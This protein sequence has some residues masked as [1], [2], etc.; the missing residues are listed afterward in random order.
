MVATDETAQET[1]DRILHRI[2]YAA[3]D[4]TRYGI[5]TAQDCRDNAC[6]GILGWRPCRCYAGRSDSLGCMSYLQSLHGLCKGEKSVCG[7]G[8]ARRWSPCRW[9]H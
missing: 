6:F 5:K 1:T 9:L 4:T 7:C 2:L 3:D 8:D